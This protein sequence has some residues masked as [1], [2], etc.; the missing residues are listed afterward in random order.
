MRVILGAGLATFILCFLPSA[1]A[2][3]YQLII[4]GKVTMQDGSPPPKTVGIERICSDI[5]GSAPGPITD[6]KGEYLWRMDVD[7]M[8]TRACRLR[9]NLPGYVSTE[10]DISALNGYIKKEIELETIILGPRSPDPNSLNSSNSDVPAKARSAWKAAMM[11]VDAGNPQEAVTHLQQVVMESP[12]FGRGWHTLGLLYDNIDKLPEARD[13]YQHAIEA[14]PKLLPPYVMLSK[15]CGRLRDW[16]CGRQAA[17]TYLKLDA[18]RLYPEVYFYQAVALYELKNL[19]GAKASAEEA[20]QEA[21]R[22][23]LK[24]K[25]VRAEFVLAKVAAAKRDYPA[26]RDHVSKYLAADPNTPDADQLKAY[27]QLVG[28]PEGAGVDPAL[29]LP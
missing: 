16:E 13:A 4:R 20:L 27:L 11:A 5:Q 7:P 9:A 25:V 15:V 28:K 29:Q 1:R 12:K 26:A 8:N 3:V 10:I 14:D 19:D 21:N 17:D 22:P 6:K 24:K 2:D 23:D 18:K